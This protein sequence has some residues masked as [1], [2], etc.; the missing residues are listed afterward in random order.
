[1]VLDRND[2]RREHPLRRRKDD[3]AD[4]LGDEGSD[5]LHSFQHLDPR[6]G[7]TRLRR[8]GLEAVDEGLQVLALGFLPFGMLGAEQLAAVRCSLEGS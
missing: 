2:G 7:L 5:R 6:L 8:L 3:L 1:M 4:V